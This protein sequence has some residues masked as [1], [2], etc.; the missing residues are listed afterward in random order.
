MSEAAGL[1]SVDGP[2]SKAERSVSG[3]K[4]SVSGVESSVSEADGS[5]LADGTVFEVEGSEKK[6]A[7]VEK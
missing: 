1:L 6:K 2:V 5:T 3:A 4:D 7:Q